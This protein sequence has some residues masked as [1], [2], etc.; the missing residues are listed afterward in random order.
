MIKLQLESEAFMNQKQLEKNPTE[1]TVIHKF[2]EDFVTC[3]YVAKV[4]KNFHA[5]TTTW[6]KNLTSHTLYI[7]VENLS[8]ETHFTCKIDLKS[9]QFW[10]KKGFKS[11]KVGEKRAD[12]YWDL[13]S[14]KFSSRPEPVSDYYVALVSEG[15]MILLLGDQ[16]KEA[17]KRTKSR[18]ALMDVVLVHKKETVY[19][20]KYF[21][22]RTMLGQGKKQHD[23]T[24]ECVISGPSDPAMWISV[25]GTVSIRITNLHW[26]FRGNETVFVDNVPVEIFWDVH[27]WLYSGPH[28]GPGTFI[29]KQD[30]NG[31]GKLERKYSNF[32]GYI[33]DGSSDLQSACTEFWYFLY[34][35]KIE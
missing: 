18:P 6:S 33:S 19:A 4:A 25:D 28:S 34:A 12:I 2:G 26:R 7:V 14:A 1:E 32:E 15:E 27:D 21:C 23:I 17:F 35:W 22:T 13:R 30:N 24:I 31:S 9:W 20:K 11:F 16:N 5:I 3:I 10:G 29:F 8:E